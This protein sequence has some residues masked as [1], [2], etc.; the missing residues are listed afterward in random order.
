MY[1]V[2]TVYLDM[3]IVWLMLLVL[4]E[5]NVFILY[6]YLCSMC[7]LSSGNLLILHASALVESAV[8]AICTLLVVTPVGSL[9]VTSCEVKALSDWYTMFYNPSPDYVHTIHCTQEAVYPL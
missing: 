5:F 6:Y 2:N 3:C 9:S 7:L 1:S 4:C 8:A